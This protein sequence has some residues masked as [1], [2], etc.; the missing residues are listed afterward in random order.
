MIFLD[1]TTIGALA[2]WQDQ[3]HKKLPDPDMYAQKARDFESLPINDKRRRSGFTQY[4]PEVLPISRGRPT[5]PA[6]WNSDKRVKDALDAWSHG[7]C[8]YCESLINARHS[9]QVEHFKPKS[10]FP[11]LAYDWSN[12]FLACDGCNS[13][14][15]D[16]WTGTGD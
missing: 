6:V 1:R 14:K 16:K 8:A 11:S 3:V 13:A 9:Q 7:K 10:L 12:Y 15:L 5:F 4:A 2:D